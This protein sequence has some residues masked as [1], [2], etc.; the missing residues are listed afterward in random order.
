MKKEMLRRRYSQRTIESYLFCIEKFLSSVTKHPRKI[1][2][3]DIKDYLDC[4]ALKDR[5]GST[6]NIHLCSIKFLLEEVLRRNIHLRMKYS[7]KPK[8]L[9]VVLTKN[10]VKRFFA[11]VKNPKHSLMVQLMYSA[12]LRLSELLNLKARDLEFENNFG[13]IRHGKGNK[14]RA[15]ILAEKLKK[16]I[17]EFAGMH[18]LGPDDFLFKG[19]KRAHMHPRSVQEIVRKAAKKAR[20]MKNVHPH[21]LR[22]SFAT[23]LI[24]N[25]SRIIEVQSLLGHSSIETTRTYLHT[26]NVRLISVKSPL[27]SL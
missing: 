7:R 1:T 6:L 15:F 18:K 2:K 27:D 14:D 9:P 4:L 21:T 10:E 26:A 12:G 19:I 16:R 3:K 23:H 5:A 25:G 22:H 11:A 8:T 13:W 24:E 20:I 17:L